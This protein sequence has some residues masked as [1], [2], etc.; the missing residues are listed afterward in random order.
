[1]GESVTKAL[2]L[3]KKRRA[4]ARPSSMHV[5][6]AT[7]AFKSSVARWQQ[8]L[9]PP[10][11]QVCARIVTDRGLEFLTERV[12]SKS[13]TRATL[14]PAVKARTAVAAF[15]GSRSISPLPPPEPRKPSMALYAKFEL[16]KLRCAD[17]W[18]L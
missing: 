11:L 12:R 1:M 18:C 5:D 16:P 6:A 17:I 3:E 8:G 10:A 4:Q 9:L 14:D 7:I 2:Q 15:A 13:L